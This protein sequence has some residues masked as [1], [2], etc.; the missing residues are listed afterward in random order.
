MVNHKKGHSKLRVFWLG[1]QVKSG[2]T[3]PLVS[4]Q[5]FVMKTQYRKKV[6]G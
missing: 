6:V 2:N 4:L 3:G 1:P 5:S